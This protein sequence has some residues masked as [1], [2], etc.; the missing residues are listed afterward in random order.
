MATATVAPS[1]AP[2]SSVP[3]TDASPTDE[4]SSHPSSE[5]SATD[6]TSPEPTGDEPET[7]EPEPTELPASAAECTGSDENVAFYAE[8]AR[9]VD[10]AVYCPSCRPAG[11]SAP[12]SGARPMASASRSRTAVRVAPA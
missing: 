10:W 11:S 9:I 5:P 2:E 6:P 1:D 8:F 12:V 7:P 4:P 3:T